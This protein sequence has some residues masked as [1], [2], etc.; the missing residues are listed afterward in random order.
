MVK[1]DIASNVIEIEPG[2]SQELAMTVTNQSTILDLYTIAIQPIF[3]PET[4]GLD[5]GWLQVDTPQFSLRPPVPG[6]QTVT[7]ESRRR[8]KLV[9][10]IPP[11]IQAGTYTGQLNVIAESGSENSSSMPFTIVVAEV[12][13]QTLT[14]HPPDQTHNKK[15]AIYKVV[16]TN[17]GNAPLL[18]PLYAEDR[19]DAVKLEL[20]P[21]EVRLEPMQQASVTLRVQP[22][23]R[24]WAKPTK[25]YSFAIKADDFPLE[26]NGVFRQEPAL[27]I[28]G[29]IRRHVWQTIVA[30]VALIALIIGLSVWLFPWLLV[31]PPP[32]GC[33]PNSNREVFVSSNDFNTSI[34]VQSAVPGQPAVEVATIPSTQMPGIFA[35]MV[36]VSPDGRRLAYVTANNLRLERATLNIY[37]IDERRI[38][39]TVTISGTMGTLWTAA[40]I[41]SADGERIVYLTRP[42]AP[43]SAPDGTSA[44]S[45]APSIPTPPPS[46]TIALTATVAGL[47]TATPTT[48]GNINTATAVATSRN[49]N[50]RRL[51]AWVW[52]IN[53]SNPQN[54]LPRPLAPQ[55]ILDLDVDRYYGDGGLPQNRPLCWNI[56]NQHVIAK[57]RP[58]TDPARKVYD[59]MYTLRGEPKILGPTPLPFIVPSVLPGPPTVNVGT[60]API[61]PVVPRLQRIEPDVSG[62]KA[63]QMA[64]L[65]S[66]V[67]TSTV[68]Q[69]LPQ[70]C[71]IKQPLSMNDPEWANKPILAGDTSRRIGDFGC[72]LV[73][74]TMMLNAAGT[75]RPITPDSLANCLDS[76]N[77]PDS[78]LVPLTEE[79]WRAMTELCGNGQL[80]GGDRIDFSWSRMTEKLNEGPV[81]VGLLGK[82]TG[83]HFVIVTGGQDQKADTYTVID[84]WD[85]STYKTL[86][87][88]LDWGYGLRWMI[89]FQFGGGACGVSPR[90][91]AATPLKILTS[92]VEDGGLYSTT[93]RLVIETSGARDAVKLTTDI[94]RT[95]PNQQPGRFEPRT[96]ENEAQ[97]DFEQEGSY[98]VFITAVSGPLK[99]ERTMYFVVDKSAPDVNI[100]FSPLSSNRVFSNTIVNIDFSASDPTSSIGS[101]EYELAVLSLGRVLPI[102]RYTSDTGTRQLTINR[103][104]TFVVRYRSINGAGIAS[105]FKEEQFTI[106]APSNVAAGA[107]AAGGLPNTGAQ[108]GGQTGGTVG[109]PNTPGNQGGGN[110][111][112]PGQ[113]IANPGNAAPPT[114]TPV[115][116][117]PVVPAATPR[118]TNTPVPT[119]A[120]TTTNPA[121]TPLL[122][123]A[124]VSPFPATPEFSPTPITT[125]APVT[126]T[127]TVSPTVAAAPRLVLNTTSLIF[128]SNETVQELVLTNEGGAGLIWALL[129][130]LAE[131]F[132]EFDNL[133]A[134][135]EAGQSV[136]V[137]VNLRAAAF[138]LNENT[139]SFR[140]S[141]G[142]L[143]FDVS[144]VIR[145]RVSATADFA[146]LASPVLT[147]EV[148]IKINIGNQVGTV[149]PDFA[150]ITGTFQACPSCP[151]STVRLTDSLGR[152]LEPSPSN[153]WTI[154]WN[155]ANFPPQENISLSGAVCKNPANP[156][157]TPLPTTLTGLRILLAANVSSPTPN[158]VLN[159]ITN[160]N[161]IVQLNIPEPSGNRAR[162]A[163]IFVS[164]NDNGVISTLPTLQTN[165]ATNW[166]VTVDTNQI[167]PDT[168]MGSVPITI[169]GQ[170]C[171]GELSTS[172][173]VDI[174]PVSQLTTKLLANIIGTDVSNPPAAPTFRLDNGISLPEE[175]TLTAQPSANV[176]SM[177]AYLKVKV[178]TFGGATTEITQSFTF[179]S[180]GF[181]ASLTTFQYPPQNDARLAVTACYRGT[182][183]PC[184]NVV[185][186]TNL[187]IPVRPATQITATNETKNANL[188]TPAN[189]GE[190]FNTPLIAR[191]TDANGVGV[192]GVLVTFTLPT[193][194]TAASGL[195]YLGS[196]FAPT[197][198][199][200]TYATVTNQNG[201]ARALNILANDQPGQWTALAN[202]NGVINPAEF[203]LRNVRPGAPR[204]D[205]LSGNS[206][207]A[208][209][210]TLYG[211]ELR[212]ILRD[213]SG[214]PQPG[215]EVYFVSSATSPGVVFTG[216]LSQTITATTDANGI[217]RSGTFRANNFVG[218]F[219]VGVN[220]V[221]FDPVLFELENL[222]GA[223]A[224]IV[225]LSPLSVSGKILE[226]L[227]GRFKVEVTDDASPSGTK[228]AGVDVTFTSLAPAGAAGGN[229]NNNGTLTKSITVRTG[230]DGS[231]ESLPFVLNDKASTTPHL[232]QVTLVTTTVPAV[233]FS[234]VNQPGNPVRVEI[235]APGS[236]TYEAGATPATSFTG[237][238]FDA[239]S[240]PVNNTAI[241]FVARTNAGT[242]VPTGLWGG[243]FIVTRTTDVAGNPVNAGAFVAACRPANNYQVDVTIPGFPAVTA[244][245][246][247]VTIVPGPA[248]VI[249]P[250]TAIVNAIANQNFNTPLGALVTDGCATFPNPVSGVNVL[251]ELNNGASGGTFVPSGFVTQTATT[252]A[253]GVATTSAIRA[254]TVKGNF[255]ATAS[256]VPTNTITTSG[257]ALN[258]NPDAPASVITSQTTISLTAP[259]STTYNTDTTTLVRV[260]DQFG[261]RVNA[262]VPVTFTITTGGTGASGRFP[263]NATTFS[264]V[265][266][267]NGEARMQDILANTIAGEFDV[268]VR[269]AAIPTVYLF[270]LTNI[271]GNVYRI[272][273]VSLNGDTTLPFSRTVN[274]NIQL[275]IRTFDFSGNRAPGVLVNYSSPATGAALNPRT[276]SFTTASGGNPNDRGEHQQTFQVNTT[277]NTWNGTG[278]DTYNIT[279][280]A[281]GG[282]V[283]TNVTFIN[284][285]AAPNNLLFTAPNANIGNSGTPVEGRAGEAFPTVQFT[286]RD[287][288]NNPIPNAT[289]SFDVGSNGGATLNPSTIATQNLNNAN[290]Q[291]TVT[292]MTANGTVNPGSYDI[293]VDVTSPYGNANP[294]GR[295]YLRNNAGLP[296]SVVA[297]P[298][299]PLATTVGTTFNGNNPIQFTVEDRFGNEVANEPV[300]LTLISGTPGASATSPTS[301]TVLNTNAS[302]VASVLVTANSV[303][304]T[305]SL[306]AAAGVTATDTVALQNNVGAANN[307]LIT[308]A[309]SAATRSQ[310]T[311]GDDFN[312]GAGFVITVRDILNNPISGQNVTFSVPGTGATITNTLGAGVTDAS[313][314]YTTPVLFANNTVGTFQVGV[315]SGAVNAQIFL[316]NVAPAI[317]ITSGNNQNALVGAQ[318]G[319]PLAVNVTGAG[320]QPVPNGTTVRYTVTAGNALLP[321]GVTT[322]NTTTTGGTASTVI[323]AGTNVSVATYNVTVEVIMGG[324]PVATNNFTLSNRVTLSVISGSGQ[325]SITGQTFAPLVVRATGAT[326]GVNNVRIRYSVAAAANG[327]FGGAGSTTLVTAGTGQ[328]SAN[329]LVA[330]TTLNY[331]VTA[332][333]VDGADAPITGIAAVTFALSNQS[334]TLTIIDGDNQDA[335]FNGDT[336]AEGFEVRV[337]RTDGTN[338]SGVPVLYTAV[339][340]A[341]GTFGSVGG[342]ATLTVNTN[343]SGVAE[344]NV[345]VAAQR[346]FANNQRGAHT[347]TAQVTIGSV[348]QTVIFDLQNNARIVA[349]SGVTNISVSQGITDVVTFPVSVT[350]NVEDFAG[351]NIGNENLTYTL[352]SVA[353]RFVDRSFGTTTGV[354]TGTTA[355][356]A[357]NNGTY[358]ST[359]HR[360]E[361]NNATTTYTL[362]V[363]AT[364]ARA[365]V[366]NITQS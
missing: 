12:E 336:F 228:L 20:I 90:I 268:Q 363:S 285:P 161:S 216:S 241:Q 185:T 218:D 47:P 19:A 260:D 86:Q 337:T 322:F 57:V 96:I 32:F 17:D 104:G 98:E 190:S 56:D 204:V 325:I 11:N 333:V 211:Q 240:N 319:Q 180:P 40:P 13:K 334:F 128:N 184:D 95:P 44:G 38:L 71:G 316:Q 61:S 9:L 157:C 320:G 142:G 284:R 275:E 288:F 361:T 80:G 278:F 209:I 199:A 183:P 175:F 305:Y 118:P 347:V 273:V 103:A 14:L 69:N 195:F 100:S 355:A 26:A 230:P 63:G 219:I 16:L 313:G 88:F 8:L 282:A 232:V 45:G 147:P 4:A 159:T 125:A 139:T 130:G 107:S 229:F 24:N 340:P 250:T 84:P 74:T 189:V 34:F 345:A 146:P 153:N 210:Q 239:G 251:F 162:K 311:I 48:A 236:Q 49:F 25:E 254:N 266:D 267:A 149:L 177:T 307:I 50:P 255:T 53:V 156:I 5:V 92:G 67:T 73:A 226:T 169:T 191:V 112:P 27:P 178:Y 141:G 224:H 172:I 351:N 188:V 59:V 291:V 6:S 70:L 302:G 297:N 356:A 237:Q 111:I 192:A 42:A 129:P 364:N 358:N 23:R 151:V 202:T 245:T 215:V 30:I 335:I 222:P 164:Y 117:A 94:R 93:Q 154:V 310:A 272:E 362:T 312:N 150:I 341:R 262:G 330:G 295:F 298:A 81:I 201:L 326:G 343:A 283:I 152:G 242:G 258:I 126:P 225:R 223:P 186:Y 238:A 289:V 105:P 217:A 243:A 114:L 208:R 37:N 314:Q 79:G 317:N 109:R 286:I 39:T 328:T 212:V 194:P 145:A 62:G 55:G 31:P 43:G 290:G 7:D 83:T 64:I 274:N 246:Y 148:G 134:V 327:N 136:R 227:P 207:K 170:V 167:K 247:N 365:L 366:F 137:R 131:T 21:T 78:R 235:A 353:G 3:T 168:V 257:F 138:S 357:P 75:A 359:T 269:A 144:V 253:S 119:L 196:P 124:S 165:A 76:S 352:S 309:T 113:V 205:I 342:N 280:S 68:N 220:A 271:P 72:P 140:V 173:C 143:N 18:I 244:K 279:F 135:L 2:A 52:E 85:G 198:T 294:V 65:P 270:H 132:L 171:D 206:Q 36:S 133:G 231:I 155:T 35:S 181:T 287:N 108:T 248:R 346:F 179:F 249:T 166:Q 324:T 33:V 315:T 41:W 344:N 339:T 338:L 265:T 58:S 160:S 321:G 350:V 213:N 263:G 176:N 122:P 348:S 97:I 182:T 276:G 203:S 110:P 106:Q 187:I 332:Q 303:P 120:P 66:Q 28:L 60:P 197:F 51:D 252:N 234:V 277:S 174:P 323:T 91:P 1:V 293:E 46:P 115:R 261:N 123:T 306:S 99:A 193:G 233:N 308:P 301:G 82:P 116:I 10:T 221:N 102:A 121:G 29:W 15:R 296:V 158:S 77:Q 318:F 214:N 89:D 360:F 101:I 329:N 300:T 299:G 200:T 264:T 281:A 259:V 54:F 256:V 292:G 354:V 87:N 349:V 163:L 304:G 22:Y 127:A 331:N